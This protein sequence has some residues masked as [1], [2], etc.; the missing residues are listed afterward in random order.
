VR[1]LKAALDRAG[2]LG[3]RAGVPPAEWP[4][5]SAGSRFSPDPDN[6]PAGLRA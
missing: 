4:T 6:N 5:T 1:V 2:E 3:G